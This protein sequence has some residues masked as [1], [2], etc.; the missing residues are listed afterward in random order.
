MGIALF[1]T[2]IV[3]VFY[4]VVMRYVFNSPTF[5]TEALARNAMIWLVFLGLARGVRNLDNIR[6]DFLVE[7]MPPWLQRLS[8]WIR[9]VVLVCFSSVMVYYGLKLAIS[10]R[11][12]IATG[13]EIPVMFIYLAVPVS[14]ALILLFT[15]EL[16]LNREIRPF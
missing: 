6:V 8:A 1:S 16:I 12:Q 9:Y 7:H 11:N 10:N 2:M 3:V 4:E 15:L 13:F 14:G 5:W